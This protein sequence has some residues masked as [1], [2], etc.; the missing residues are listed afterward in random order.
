MKTEISQII[1][2]I[3]EI[4]GK[5]LFDLVLNQ[6]QSAFWPDL[7][8]LSVTIKSGNSKAMQYWWETPV[9]EE[10]FSRQDPHTQSGDAGALAA[11]PSELFWVNTAACEVA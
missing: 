3:V 4:V 6:S 9:W 10:V 5:A 1:I 2:V 8:M 11:E 7:L